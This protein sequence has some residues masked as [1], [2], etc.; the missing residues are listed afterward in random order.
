MREAFSIYETEPLVYALIC[1]VLQTVVNF[2]AQALN[3]LVLNTSYHAPGIYSILSQKIL[4]HFR[5]RST[6]SSMGRDEAFPVMILNQYRPVE[7]GS[8]CCSSPLESK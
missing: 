6:L 3:Y 1:I 7:M 8:A 4:L 2:Q 5:Q